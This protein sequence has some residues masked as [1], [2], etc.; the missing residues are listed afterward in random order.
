MKQ[1]LKLINI[2]SWV[3]L[4]SFLAFFCSRKPKQVTTTTVKYV[5]DTV[6]RTV[7]VLAPA[8]PI[9][10][11]TPADTFIQMIPYID[12]A[13]CKQLAIAYYSQ[14]VYSHTLVDDSLLTASIVDT[15]CQNKIGHRA[16]IYRINRPQTIITNTT[17][18][19]EK[20]TFSLSIGA[21]VTKLPANFSIAPSALVNYKKTSIGYT[22]D[23]VNRYHQMTYFFKIVG[24]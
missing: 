18:V 15:I 7:T 17:M 9:K 22:Y 19:A 11:I 24:K 14:S 8:N 16:F 4:V 10:I 6:V 12:S 1:Y 5:R 21:T 2:L 20:P 13:Y 3:V 23:F